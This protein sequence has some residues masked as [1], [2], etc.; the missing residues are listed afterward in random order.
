MW[1]GWRASGGV[2]RAGAAALAAWSIYAY[3]ILG[4]QVHE[5]H[6]YPALPLLALAAGELAVLRSFF[7]IV[8][9]I[10]AFNLYLF[11][12]LGAGHPP[13]INRS[14]S[15]IDFT[16]W[17]SLAN[18]VVF[19]VFTRRVAALTRGGLAQP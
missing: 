1:A 4:A 18:V 13:I 15:G 8:S 9:G 3:V 6:L 17:L 10:F 14:W 7:W 11:Y 19:V 16:V 12:G 5:N 2:T